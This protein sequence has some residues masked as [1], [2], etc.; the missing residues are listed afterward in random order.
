MKKIKQGQY[1]GKLCAQ[2]DQAAEWRAT[3]LPSQLT[4][5]Y[6]CSE[7]KQMIVDAELAARPHVDHVSEADSQTWMQL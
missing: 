6:A 1:E 5:I 3:K 4:K 2:C 7:H